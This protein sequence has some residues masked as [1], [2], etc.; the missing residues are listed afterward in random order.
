MD[1]TSAPSENDSTDSLNDWNTLHKLIVQT[2]LWPIHISSDEHGTKNF[3]PREP[4]K[5]KANISNQCKTM[6]YLEYN[7]ALI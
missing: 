1:T 2:E 5:R 6:V 4:M 7:R 3:L